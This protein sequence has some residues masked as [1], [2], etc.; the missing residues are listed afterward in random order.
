MYPLNGHCN[1]LYAA[2]QKYSV[3]LLLEL[4]CRY[5]K[6]A[7]NLWRQTVSR[8]L[9]SACQRTSHISNMSQRSPQVRT[10]TTWFCRKASFPAES[11]G[12][13]V[14]RTECTAWCLQVVKGFGVQFIIAFQFS[15]ASHLDLYSDRSPV[16][17]PS[18][19]F[20]LWIVTDT[21][22]LFKS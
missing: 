15:K 3:T 1:S 22:K 21:D 8:P 4:P 12:V 6:Q 16:Q 20:F 7:F 17:Y 13:K 10:V 9:Q 5:C 11:Q 2:M 19:F 18:L 14:G